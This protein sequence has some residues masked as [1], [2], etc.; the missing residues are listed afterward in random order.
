M[1]SDGEMNKNGIMH[2]SLGIQIMN[3]KSFNDFRAERRNSEKVF[4]INAR[5]FL[6]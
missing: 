1:I 2:S 4:D 6:R 5:V 3:M